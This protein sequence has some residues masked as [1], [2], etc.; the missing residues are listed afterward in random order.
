MEGKV[1]FEGLSDKGNK[2]I[3]RYPIKDDAEQMRDYLNT[4]SKEQTFI[5]FQGE[6]VTL[7]HER[8]YLN[9]QL[10]RIIKKTTVELFVFCNN[11]LIG[12]SLSKEYRG[13]G[14]GKI[15]MK[16]VLEEAERHMSQLRI[17]TLGVFG[18][19]ELA[20]SMY[21]KFGFKEYGRLPKGIL[22]KGKYIDHIYM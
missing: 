9:R 22:R 4:L 3:I 19:N 21:E 1:V 6:Q 18:G 10:K 5:R 7:G 15:F 20:R 13:E 14:I 16:M 11:K 12:I 8:K 17:I 2:I